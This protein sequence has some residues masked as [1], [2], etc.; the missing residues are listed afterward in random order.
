MT[1][2]RKGVL[3]ISKSYSMAECLNAEKEDQDQLE[4]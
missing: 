3:L 2:C 1:T 4:M